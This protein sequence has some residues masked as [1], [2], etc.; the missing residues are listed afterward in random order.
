MTFELAIV[1]ASDFVNL[2]SLKPSLLFQVSA[3]KLAHQHILNGKF[4]HSSLQFCQAHAS[5]C[6]QCGSDFPC[7]TC[8]FKYKS[9]DNLQDISLIIKRVERVDPQIWFEGQVQQRLFE[10]FPDNIARC[11]GNYEMFYYFIRKGTSVWSSAKISVFVEQ[12]EER[13]RTVSI[14]SI[15]SSQQLASQPT[16]KFVVEFDELTRQIGDSLAEMAILMNRPTSSPSTQLR[17]DWMDR[18]FLRKH[19][20][21]IVPSKISG[22][23]QYVFF[24]FGHNIENSAS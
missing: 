16:E 9:I 17:I 12:K 24:D 18:D 4:L 20:Y 22:T 11:V 3:R 19:N 10:Q 21:F 15:A 6:Q 14:D 5:D 23:Y 7:E 2:E 13:R 8:F 1:R